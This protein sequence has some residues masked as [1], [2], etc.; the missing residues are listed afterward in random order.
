MEFSRDIPWDTPENTVKN[1]ILILQEEANQMGA[2]FTPR[3]KSEPQSMAKTITVDVGREHKNF[4]L[5]ISYVEST[6]MEL[7]DGHIGNGII[8]AQDTW[9]LEL[10]PGKLVP[11]SPP[12]RW[13]LT[14]D[15]AGRLGPPP[16]FLDGSL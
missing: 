10:V 9:R 2:T 4:R 11:Y 12:F 13:K 1:I 7:V 8:F 15:E 3:S 6:L 16:R 14:W 5:V